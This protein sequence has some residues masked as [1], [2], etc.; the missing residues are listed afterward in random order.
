MGNL[1]KYAHSLAS[2]QSTPNHQQSCC[3]GVG[4]RRP[5]LR[6]LSVHGSSVNSGS[7]TQVSQKLLHASR[8]DFLGR[9]YAISPEIFILCFFFRSVF[10]FFFCLF[11]FT[12]DLSNFIINMVVMGKIRNIVHNFS[13]Q[14]AKSLKKYGSL[15]FSLTRDPGHGTQDTR[16]TGPYVR[17]NFK[18]ILQ[19]H[20][21]SAKLY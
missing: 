9:H 10:T 21:I 17:G 19:F 5:T 12:W 15:K 14:A 16:D 4:V 3:R 1:T 13:W 6:P 20:L 18:V 7:G 11:S 8:L 2:P